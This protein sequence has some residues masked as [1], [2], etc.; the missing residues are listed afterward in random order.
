VVGSGGIAQPF[1]A[2]ALEVSA[3]LRGPSALPPAKEPPVPVAEEAGWAPEPSECC[4]LEINHL[5]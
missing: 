4:G 1:F 2:S 5:P 3:Q